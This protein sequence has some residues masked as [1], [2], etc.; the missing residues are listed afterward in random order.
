MGHP[1]DMVNIVHKDQIR[2]DQQRHQ[3][4]VTS[5]QRGDEIQERKRQLRFESTAVEADTKRYGW[6]RQQNT[7]WFVRSAQHLSKQLFFQQVLD[8]HHCVSGLILIL[9]SVSKNNGFQ[10]LLKILERIFLY[11]EKNLNVFY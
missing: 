2:E 4:S 1:I 10:N 8:L 6:G 3:K 5:A 11:K 7:S 9:P